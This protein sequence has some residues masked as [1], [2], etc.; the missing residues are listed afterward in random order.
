[1]TTPDTPL[2][3]VER[4]I[5]VDFASEAAKSAIVR[6]QVYAMIDVHRHPGTL[7]RRRS[8]P[9]A[10]YDLLLSELGMKFKTMSYSSDGNILFDGWEIC[11]EPA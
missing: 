3:D 10:E 8:I 9:S 2:D 6:H 7:F 4:R 5:H 1:M 11:R